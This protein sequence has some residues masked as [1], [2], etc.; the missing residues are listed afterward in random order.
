MDLL[1]HENKCVILGKKLLMNYGVEERERDLILESWS[2]TSLV[3]N[4]SFVRIR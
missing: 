1:N 4:T 2:N 3:T